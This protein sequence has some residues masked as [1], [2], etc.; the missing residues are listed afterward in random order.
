MLKHLETHSRPPETEDLANDEHDSTIRCPRCSKEFSYRKTLARHIKKKLCRRGGNLPSPSTSAN[1]KL[2]TGVQ[3]DLFDIYAN[4]E[5]EE[6]M[7]M[8][9]SRMLS[10]STS[11]FRFACALC[12]KMF[13]SYANMCRHRQLAHGRYDFCSP[14]WLLSQKLSD[15][16]FTN[17]KSK[18]ANSVAPVVS[19]CSIVETF[20][21]SLINYFLHNVF[22]GRNEWTETLYVTKNG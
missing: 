1:T 3:S 13:D 10:C 21:V 5:K 6:E 16:Q 2:E 20:Y 19:T 18:H 22:V 17:V 8:E 11:L 7:D 12:S 14:H 15:S 4:R 9:A